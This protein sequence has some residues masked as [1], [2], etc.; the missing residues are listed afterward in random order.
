MQ[1]FNLFTELIKDIKFNTIRT[2]QIIQ[3]KVES[4]EEEAAAIA[5]KLAVE[6]RQQ[7]AQ[8]MLNHTDSDEPIMDKKTARND[9]CPCGS[10]KKYKQCCGKSGPKKGV[11][12]S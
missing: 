12:A 2:L 6:Q 1:S 4:A 9:P 11:F 7:E 10:G 3:F 5:E 8:M